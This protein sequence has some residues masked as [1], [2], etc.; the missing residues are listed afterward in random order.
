[1]PDPVFPLVPYGPPSQNGT[2]KTYIP[3]QWGEDDD[4]ADFDDANSNPPDVPAGPPPAHDYPTPLVLL[5]GD[6]FMWVTDVPACDQY[7]PFARHLVQAGDLFRHPSHASGLVLASPCPDIPPAEITKPDQLASVICDRVRIQV[8]T[9]GKLKGSRIPPADL[10]AMLTSEI[11]LREFSPLDRVVTRPL[12]L[13]SF[14]LTTPGY[15]DGGR[16]QRVVY[17]GGAPWILH[18]SE[19]INRFLD[20]MDFDGNA[21][22]TNT[23]AAA[24]T[25]LL[26]NHF[27]G[28]KP[29]VVATSTKSHGGKDTVIEFASGMTPKTSISYETQDWALQKSFVT[30]VKHDPE[31]GVVNVE[32]ARIRGNH[33][34]ASAFLERFLTDPKPT[35]YSPGTGTPVRRRNDMVVTM[36]TNFGTISEDLMNRALPIH[37]TPQGD[38]ANRKSPIGN[39]KLEYLPAYREQIEAELRGMIENWREAGMPQD[40][41]AKHPFSLWSQTIGGI[42]K[43]NGFSDFLGNYATRRTIDDPI[44]KALGILGDSRPGQL[45]SAAMWV[46]F[47]HDL[48]LVQTLLS[49]ADRE[50]PKSQARGLGVVMGKYVGETFVVETDAGVV[51][52][53]LEKLRTRLSGEEGKPRYRF[54]PVETK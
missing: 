28:G 3:S 44:K 25:V 26:R 9:D 37:L 34:I 24:L 7:G 20:V 30:H 49:Q 10:K 48:G 47:M 12:Y 29:I 54:V 27:M 5:D 42:L 32:N 52:L 39:P 40:Q 41:N 33:V 16:G 21:D 6:L 4:N 43:V 1:M 45:L 18:G 51:K 31:I 35:L 36:S 11:F 46:P 19:A 17:A 23:V 53:K 14:K 50:S 38:V 8:V 22:R 13:P 2:T 15:H